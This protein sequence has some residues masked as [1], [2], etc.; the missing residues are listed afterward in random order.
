MNAVYYLNVYTV[1]VLLGAIF[2]RVLA[3]RYKRGLRDIPGPALA[4][5]SRLWK[6]YSV[7]KGDHHHVEIDLH[8]KHG[9]L[10]RI[11][12]NHI[13]VSDPAAIPIIYGLN[14]GFT[15]AC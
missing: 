2:V 14:K 15:K 4:R 12:P 13:S 3:N 8:R 6:L 5:Y 11:G 1:Y 9:S 10:V 7:W